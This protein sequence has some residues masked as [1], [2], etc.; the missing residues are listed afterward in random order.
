MSTT[1]TAAAPAK[2]KKWSSIVLGLS[3]P[4]AVFLK[5]G[6][7]L[8]MLGMLPTLLASSL[9]RRAGAGAFSIVAAFNLAGVFPDLLSVATQGG[10]VRALTDKMGEASCWLS[11]Y[12]AAALGFAVVWL[13][14]SIA[15]LVLESVYRGRISHMQHLQRKLED[16]W[17]PQVTGKKD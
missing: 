8:L 4:L 7:F 12:G 14:P 2:P 16:E 5:M 1:E 9:F 15:M 3:L 17:G 6:L 13:S 11:M 10:T